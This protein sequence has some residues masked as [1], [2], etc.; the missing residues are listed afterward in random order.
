M[1][2]ENAII[3]ISEQT[4]QQMQA[5]AVHEQPIPVEPVAQVYQE[6]QMPEEPAEQVYQ[7]QQYVA[8]SSMI[9]QL[10]F[11]ALNEYL[12]DD[13]IVEISYNNNGQLWI[14]SQKNGLYKEDN[15]T[16]NNQFIEGLAQGCSEISGKNFNMAN[17]FL[18]VNVHDISISFI[19]SSVAKNGIAAVFSKNTFDISKIEEEIEDD[20]YLKKNVRE[21]I[22]NCIKAHCNIIVCG[23]N[24]S[25]KEELLQYLVYNIPNSE[26]IVAI[27]DE[28]Q[29]NFDAVSKARDIVSLKANNIA[30][31][32][33][34]L[35]FGLK[36]KPR[37]VVLSE[38]LNSNTAMA[39]KNVTLRGIS[40]LST[41]YANKADS[42]PYCL[43]GMLD[44]NINGDQYLNAIYRSIQLAILVKSK[45]NSSDGKYT[46]EVIGVCEFYVDKNNKM[47][48]NNIF[49]KD[50]GKESCSEPSEYL[51]KY[52]ANHGVKVD[53]LF[54]G[55]SSNSESEETENSKNTSSIKKANF[56]S[57]EES[58]EEPV[59]EEKDEEEEDTSETPE[60]VEETSTEVKPAVPINPLSGLGVTAEE[61]T[62]ELPALPS[63]GG[64][65]MQPPQLMQG[66]EQAPQLM[67]GAN[68]MAGA[69]VQQPQI[70]PNLMQVG[71]G[72]SQQSS[73]IGNPIIQQ[74]DSAIVPDMPNL[75][76]GVDQAQ[77]MNQRSG[78]M[79]PG[80][81]GGI[82]NQ[83]PPLMGNPQGQQPSLMQ[84]ANLMGG[85]SMTAESPE[86]QLMGLNSLQAQKQD[87][88]QLMGKPNPTKKKP[89]AKQKFYSGVGK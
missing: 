43:Y 84:G 52:L 41:M 4:A 69:G 8:E 85:P 39:I 45:F 88:P 55:E 12:D 15:D 36:Q 3:D 14:K 22:L 47:H 75:L 21:F 29:I 83:A 48:S 34:V 87:R 60:Q 71:P 5:A 25:G 19:H 63:L 26:K 57:V 20:K 76:S 32:S 72:P 62:P 50:N 37:W 10:D 59:E 79:L 27:E 51:K 2:E 73:M 61:P 81:G 64:N 33:S 17:P 35:N 30:S 58:E 44:S 54:N 24:D 74:P 38:V 28:S 46:H 82:S 56:N 9:D 89:F 80:F 70:G 1:N 23:D 67:K 13:D 49:L 86:A 65:V 42:I 68:L 18:D 66:V 77:N 40:V 53:S 11:G 7:E 6:Q 16:I 31:Y 78:A